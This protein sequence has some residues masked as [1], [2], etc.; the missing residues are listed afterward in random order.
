[1]RA[2]A[3]SYTFS[4]KGKVNFSRMHHCAYMIVPFMKQGGKVYTADAKK[5]FYPYSQGYGGGTANV[6]RYKV[7]T[8]TID[9]TRYVPFA[10]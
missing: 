4:L 7:Q 10:L 3:T 6:A 2:N 5:A 9:F 1:M 8:K